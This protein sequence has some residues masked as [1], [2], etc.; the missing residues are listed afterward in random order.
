MNIEQ[1]KTVKLIEPVLSIIGLKRSYISAPC[2]SLHN[3]YK[4]L[5][6]IKSWTQVEPDK[7]LK[8]G[9]SSKDDQTNY[10]FIHS[11]IPSLWNVKSYLIYSISS[12]LLWFVYCSHPIAIFEI[13]HSGY[14]SVETF[15]LTL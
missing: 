6:F 14:I 1:Q 2:T 5:S 15:F 8:H 7:N 3:D 10:G 13:V 9:S 4:K 11:C 12:L